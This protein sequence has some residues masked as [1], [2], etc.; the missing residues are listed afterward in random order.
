MGVNTAFL[1]EKIDEEVYI[2]HPEGF[3]TFNHESHVC[4]LK[5]ALYGLK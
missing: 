2:E 3:E 5:R 1:N 4:K